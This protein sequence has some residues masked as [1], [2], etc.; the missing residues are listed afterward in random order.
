MKKILIVDPS[1]S[2]ARYVQVVA[3]RLG[4]QCLSATSAREGLKVLK[5]RIVDLVL[6]EAALRDMS[7]TELCR[8][9]RGKRRNRNVPVVA[10]TVDGSIMD[11]ARNG[12]S[13]FNDIVLKPASVRELYHMLQ[14][15]LHVYSRRKHIRAPMALVATLRDGLEYRSHLTMNIGEGGMYIETEE[16]YEIGKVLDIHLPLP[17][18]K[19]ALMVQGEVL[20]SVDR[21]RPDHPPGMGLKFIDVDK[22]N[23]SLLCLYMENYLAGNIPRAE[24]RYSIMDPAT[25]ATA[26]RV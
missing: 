13:V 19:E 22:E 21:D 20:Y 26:S 2:F 7:G 9:I 8:K 10:V 24:P 11:D 18:L 25:V 4:Y 5:V 23:R 14:V 17:G 6:C 12:R 15:H 3:T 1:R 16:P